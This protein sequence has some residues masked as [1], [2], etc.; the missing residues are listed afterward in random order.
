VILLVEDHQPTRVALEHLLTK[1]HF[2]VLT[3]G[4]LGEARKIASE[5]PFDLLISDVGLPDGTGCDLMRELSRNGEVKGIALSGYGMESDVAES[6]A[7]GFARHLTKPIHA[8]TLDDA[9][10][11]L[12][13]S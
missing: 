11:D 8:Q 6:H 1:R 7:A 4:N 5:S 2:D 12:L 10:R 3:A 9:L 13:H